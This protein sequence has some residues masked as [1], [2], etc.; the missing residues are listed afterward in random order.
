MVPQQI[1]RCS[2]PRKGF[3]DL[4]GK[5]TLRGIWGDLEVNDPSAIEA[6]HDQGMKKLERRGGDHKHVDRR[7]VGQVVA[8]EAP[9]SRRGL[10]V[11]RASSAQP[12]PG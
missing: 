1:A 3:D 11:A 2:V 9:P 12:W 10:W 4:A 8:Q 7:N 6:E 5:P